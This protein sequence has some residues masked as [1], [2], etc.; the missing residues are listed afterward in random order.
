[1]NFIQKFFFKTALT[2]DIEFLHLKTMRKT[3]S[4]LLALSVAR[5]GLARIVLA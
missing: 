4:N 5:H 3:L 2:R 1:M